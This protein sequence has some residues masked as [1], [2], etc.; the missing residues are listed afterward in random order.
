[1]PLS[2]SEG[3]CVLVADDE[4]PAPEQG[5][6]EVERAAALP[7]RRAALV[8]LSQ[9]GLFSKAAIVGQSRRKRLH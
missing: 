3:L 2:A 7:A 5:I 4:A 9:V 6:E 8:R 1:M